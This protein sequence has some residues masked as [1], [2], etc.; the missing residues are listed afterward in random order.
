MSEDNGFSG[1]LIWGGMYIA[2]PNDSMTGAVKAKTIERLEHVI[3]KR[4]RELC[5]REEL[6]QEANLELE[7]A[8]AV[9]ELYKKD[10]VTW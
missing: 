10:K 9:L 7:K 1:F 4:D 8:R 5:R 3:E 2:P 6:L